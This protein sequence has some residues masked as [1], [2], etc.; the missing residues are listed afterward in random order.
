M[1]YFPEYNGWRE[2]EPKGVCLRLNVCIVFKI[3]HKTEVRKKLLTHK[4]PLK[5]SFK[6]RHGKYYL[7]G[8]ID[9]S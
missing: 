8:F 9:F 7:N 4:A 5:L 6:N 3:C 2:L 1:K